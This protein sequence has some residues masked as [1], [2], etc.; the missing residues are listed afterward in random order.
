MNIEGLKTSLHLLCIG[1]YS[2]AHNI[3]LISNSTGSFWFNEDNAKAYN[4]LFTSSVGS[5]FNNYTAL[6]FCSYYVKD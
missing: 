1:Y 2:P 3:V 4:M 5:T 6:E